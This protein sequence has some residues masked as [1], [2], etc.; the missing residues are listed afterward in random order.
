MLS[1][2]V[3][4]VSL[5]TA[6]TQADD[7]GEIDIHIQGNELSES[8]QTALGEAVD[9]N[10]ENVGNDVEVHIAVETPD[11]E[12][13]FLPPK[14]G[15]DSTGQDEVLHVEIPESVDAVG[16]YK[17]FAVTTEVGVDDPTNSANWESQLVQED[18]FINRTSGK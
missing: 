9:I 4:S 11:G 5:I 14:K 15:I 7:P 6:I 13:I 17:I 8:N 3:L 12:I 16:P 10:V 18:L 1:L 2:L